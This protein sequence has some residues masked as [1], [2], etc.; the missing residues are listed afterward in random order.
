MMSR[1]SILE[2]FSQDLQLDLVRIRGNS[3]DRMGR[4]L[5]W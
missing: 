2:L 3:E 4:K 1:D 5:P